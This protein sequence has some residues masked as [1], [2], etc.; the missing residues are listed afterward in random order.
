MDLGVAL[1]AYEQPSESMEPGERPLHDPAMA[2]EARGGLDALACDPRSD[3]SSPQ[4]LAVR[5]R[6]VAL[7]RV[8]L[9]GAATRSPASTSHRLDAIHHREQRHHVRN[10]RRG[11]HRR[12]QRRALAVGDQVV[13]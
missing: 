2:A 13:F 10:V 3:A 7:V 12:R 6:A 9:V 4:A 1:V 11:Q 5:P 8:H